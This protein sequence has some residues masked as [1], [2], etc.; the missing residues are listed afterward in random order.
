MEANT[1]ICCPRCHLIH[2]VF[3]FDSSECRFAH[4]F[5][6]SSSRTC[7]Y[8]VSSVYP[9]DNGNMRGYRALSFFFSVGIFTSAWL[10]RCT[11][12]SSNMFGKSNRSCL[13][14]CRLKYQVARLQKKKRKLK[15][16]AATNYVTL[17]CDQGGITK[18]IQCNDVKNM[19]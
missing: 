17:E 5:R 12:N 1:S 6:T 13:T 16:L 7:S 11:E 18:H 2:L 8:S 9:N 4:C 19:T 10:I 3:P 15:I 14:K